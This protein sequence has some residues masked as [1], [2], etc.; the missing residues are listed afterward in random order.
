METARLIYDGDC[1]FC[2]RWALRFRRWSRGR[3][4]LETSAEAAAR[5]PGVE[6]A[7]FE[8]ALAF[9]S[10]EGALAWAAEAA[11]LCLALN[12]WLAWPL[13]LYRRA[14]GFAWASEAA[15]RWIAA[16]RKLLSAGACVLRG[17]DLGGSYTFSRWLFL[18]GLALVYAVAFA[19][20]DTQLDGLL[21]RRG[22]LP[23][24]DFLAQARRQLGPQAW[25][26]LPTLAWLNP[27]DAALHAL[28]RGGLALALL[29][30]LGLGTRAAYAALWLCYLSLCV[31]GQDFL[32]FQWDNL[33]LEAGLLAALSAP[34]SLWDRPDRP[35]APGVLQLWAYRWLL[36]RLML[37]S[38][39]VKLASGDPHWR[40]LTA[41]DFHYYTQPLP[42]R[43][44][45]WAQQAP[46]WFHAAS[47]A[48]LFGVELGLPWL[49]FLGRRPRR[50]ALVGLAL[51][52]LLISLTGNYGFFNLLTLLLCLWLADDA[53]FPRAWTRPLLREKRLRA[54]PP[55]P[56]LLLGAW[57]GLGLL[58]GSS[59]LLEALDVGPLPGLEALA[60][61]VE[62]LRS[63]NPYGLF[64]VMTTR[65]REL[66]L[67]GSAD[68]KAWKAYGWRWKPDDPDRPPAW[69]QPHM[70]RLD[71]QLWFAALG[72][73]RENPWALA[74]MGRVLQGEPTVL[75]LLGKNPFAL[76][77]PKYVR[78]RAYDYRFTDGEE[79][80]RDGAWWK[81]SLEG[82]WAG[83]LKLR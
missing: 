14:P 26:W 51:L 43:L 80:G 42:T 13:W 31:A 4:G 36:F 34:W 70:P 65:R 53:L 49:I 8:R 82:I 44:A 21:G 69:V 5:L 54:L 46:A 10:G 41:L 3:V 30:L 56:A 17:A 35:Q 77:P 73:P 16:H 47:A 58:L 2:E 20:L 25:R 9:Q 67:E 39:L 66:V 18:R 37:R 22:L 52:Q 72:G 23:A 63:L 33:L 81:R 71:W 38:G 57:V 75:E 45:W 74:L 28:A 62:P 29:A 48:L 61:A 55:R 79:R 12:P 60:A 27:G 50:L 6:R 83:P 59:Q 7:R 15:Y 78:M 76:A 64:A 32:G 40:D 19:S 11:F 1:G 68:G 24:A